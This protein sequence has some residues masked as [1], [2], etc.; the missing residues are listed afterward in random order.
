MSIRISRTA[1]IPIW[2][3]MFG[4]IALIG[5]PVT[6]TS[7]VFLLILWSVALGIVLV[8]SRETPPTVAEVLHQVDASR[9]S[10]NASRAD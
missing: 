10:T 5:P 6:S 7:G 1:I 9:E 2:L 3:I 4:L 8:L